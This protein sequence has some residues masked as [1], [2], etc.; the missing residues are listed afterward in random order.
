M[1]FHSHANK[2][3]FHNKGCAL[4]LIL[5]LRGLM[6]LTS[7]LFTSR[8]YAKEMHIPAHPQTP[9][10]NTTQKMTYCLIFSRARG[11]LSN[12]SWLS[13]VAGNGLYLG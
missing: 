11:D 10:R 13:R 12:V 3:H 4:G 8:K 9:S 7:G 2:T 6:K 1:I 5:K